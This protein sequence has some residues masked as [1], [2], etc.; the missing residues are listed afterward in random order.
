MSLPAEFVRR[1]YLD[2]PERPSKFKF[3]LAKKNAPTMTIYDI[4]KKFAFL[5]AHFIGF[6]P[7]AI[8]FVKAQCFFFRDFE[9]LPIP[10]QKPKLGQI[11]A[12]V[13]D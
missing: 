11:F 9:G 5:G 12:D 3:P 13:H 1:S 7:L 4:V 10:Q 8:C 2:R 6:D